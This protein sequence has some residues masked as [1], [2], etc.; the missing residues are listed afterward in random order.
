MT[1]PFVAVRILDLPGAGVGCACGSSGGLEQAILNKGKSEELM[2]ALA[3]S[4]PGRTSM[5]YID[6]TQAPELEETEVAQLLV[7]RQYPPPIVI[8]DDEP[9]FAGS[10][11]INKILKEVGKILNA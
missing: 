7:T 8:I 4:Y 1:K 9:R 2:D 5:E 3:K 11:Q 6:L 10:I